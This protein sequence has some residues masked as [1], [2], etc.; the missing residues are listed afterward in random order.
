MMWNFFLSWKNA[1]LDDLGYEVPVARSGEEALEVIAAES[2]GLVLLDLYM[3][4][5]D[6]DEICRQ[7]RGDARWRYLPVIVV[8]AAGKDEQIKRCLESGCDDYLTKP[9]NKNLILEKIQRQLGKVRSRMAPRVPVSLNVQIQAGGRSMEAC[10]RDISKN[11]IYLHQ[12]ALRA[13]S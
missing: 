11:G 12:A 3:T 2:P 9:I 4:G 1:F 5:I 8:T 7:L 6:G 13:R 10:A